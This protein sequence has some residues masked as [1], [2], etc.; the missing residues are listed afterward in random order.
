MT[1]AISLD[2]TASGLLPAKA[3][4][5]IRRQHSSGMSLTLLD[6]PLFRELHLT[7]SPSQENP[8]GALIESLAQLLKH[9]EAAVVRQLVFGSVAAY[10]ETMRTM[11]RILGEVDWPVMW[12]EGASCA[13]TPIA[14]MQIHAIAGSPVQ[15]LVH[16]GRLVGRVYGDGESR[17]CV[18]G[19]LGPTHVQLPAPEQARETFE[20]LEAALGLA[21]MT[22]KNVARTW[23]FLN[24]ILSWYG[25]FNTVRNAFFARSELRPGSFPAS[26][27]IGGRNPRRTALVAG[28]WAVLPNSASAGVQVVPSPRQCPAPNYGSA[29]S[30]AV[31]LVSPFHRQLL[32]SGTA[33]INAD[34]CTAYAGDTRQ[35]IELTMEVISALLR[36]RGQTF[37]DVTR[38]T[39]YFKSA[40][41]FPLFAVWCARNG[42]EELPVVSAC[43]NICR[44]DLLFEMELDA[45]ICS[46]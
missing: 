45:L 18:L 39:A 6:R 21:G 36:S 30:R 24:D 20:N 23:L 2:T 5:Q 33:S 22:L 27:G 40:A 43:C 1:P 25:P 8:A 9:H 34:G 31:E 3:I 35:Q 14:G 37:A 11:R 12:V 29:F 15:S 41:D 10:A 44:P 7:L 32:V 17:H 38:A 28:A 13:G 42:Q 4:P 26:T 19:D 46:G 16:N